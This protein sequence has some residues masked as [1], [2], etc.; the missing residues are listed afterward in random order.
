MILILSGHDDPHVPYVLP[1]LE[2]RGARV[3]WFD[4]RQFPGQSR[5]SLALDRQGV[6]T[7]RLRVDGR[8]ID[9][10]EVSAV[11][12]RR[13]NSPSRPGLPC[14]T[15]TSDAGLERSASDTLNGVFELLDC[16]WLPAKPR[17]S[18]A[19]Q[20]KPWQLA[21]AADVGFQLPETC[22]TNDPDAFLDFYGSREGRVISKPVADQ[23]PYRA[24]EP[25]PLYT[26]VVERRQAVNA[27]N[28][29]HAPVMFQAYVPKRCELRVTVVGDRIF[30][31]SIDS[32]ASRSTTDDWRHY[33]DDRV[34]YAPYRLPVDVEEKCFE[35]VR[36]FD[37]TYG[38]IDLVLT[39]D[40]QYVFLGNQPERPMGLR[41]RPSG[42]SDRR[43]HRRRVDEARAVRPGRTWRRRLR[44][45]LARPSLFCARC[46]T[47]A[48]SGPSQ[49]HASPTSRND[50]RRRASRRRPASWLTTGFE[51][52]VLLEHPERGTVGIT[53]C[54]DD[55]TPWAITYADHWASNLVVSVDD[56][57][58]TLQEALLFLK[59]A[60]EKASDLME[61]L[62]SEKIVAM[63][64]Q[65]EP[66]PVEHG[67]LQAAADAFRIA[68]GLLTEYRR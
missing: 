42:P 34:T 35:L 14:A 49:R 24:G 15:R 10:D 4:P 66:P 59:M 13:S 19:A 33:D 36:R 41:R 16:T 62:V 21:V 17:V 40:D 31:A 45:R 11:W 22:I 39:P 8:T 2:A 6:G 46:R 68:N 9:L 67:E 48:P 30:T 64:V 58:V 47:I 38:A 5:I 3:L 18:R 27:A 28:I 37:L 29:R 20:N 57:D 56:G 43:C 50:T 63:A 26:Q 12:V 55:G 60:A 51:H 61:S 25:V 7:K 1:I 53:W 52:D 44:P 23:M 54:A 65:A 32:Q